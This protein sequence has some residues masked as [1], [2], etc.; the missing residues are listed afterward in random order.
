MALKSERQALSGPEEPKMEQSTLLDAYL[1]GPET[2]RTAVAGI[3]R[4]NLISRPIAGKWSVLEVVCH[5]ADTDANI[6]HRIKRV[7]AGERPVFDRGKP[8]LILAA[9]AHN[10]PDIYEELGGFHLTSRQIA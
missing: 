6:A 4:E 3:S 5:L 2:L 9:L 1:S 7:L 10:D 8:D